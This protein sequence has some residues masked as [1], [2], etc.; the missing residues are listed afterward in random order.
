MHDLMTALEKQYTAKEIDALLLDFL[1]EFPPVEVYK[2]KC[3]AHEYLMR[4]GTDLATGEQRSNREQTLEEMILLHLA[5][6]NAAFKPF[7]LLFDDKPLAKNMNSI[8]IRWSWM[9]SIQ[10]EALLRDHPSLI[11]AK[12]SWSSP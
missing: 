6:E 3:T 11:L 12:S 5:N 2:E 8:Q 7:K 1:Q 4:K 9:S 10:E